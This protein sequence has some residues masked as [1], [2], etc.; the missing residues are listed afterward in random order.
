MATS[1]LRLIDTFPVGIN[2]LTSSEVVRMDF[3]GAVVPALADNAGDVTALVGVTFGG[4]GNIGGVMNVVTAG[5]VDVRCEPGLTLKSSQNLYVSA[6]IAGAVTNVQPGANATPIGIVKNATH[7]AASGL[8]A[9]TLLSSPGASSNIANWLLVRYFLVSYD[10]GN[11]SNVGFIDAAPGAVL[12]PTGK[13]IKTITRLLQ[14]LPFYG[15]NHVV[16]VLI[17]PRAGGVPYLTPLGGPETLDVRG[18]GGYLDGVIRGSDLTNSA[19][20]KLMC[21]GII[22]AGTNAAGYVVT[23]THIAISNATNTNPIHITLPPGHNLGNG[24]VIGL[25][26]VLGNTAANGDWFLINVVGNLADLSNSQGNGAYISGGIIGSGDKTWMQ[27]TKVGGAPA[28]LP[29]FTSSMGDRIHWTFGANAGTMSTNFCNGPGTLMV[30]TNVAASVSVGDVL[31]LELPGVQLANAFF[32]NFANTNL[33]VVG[34]NLNTNLTAQGSGAIRFAFCQTQPLLFASLQECGSLILDHRY[35]DE[36]LATRICGGNRWAGHFIRDVGFLLVFNSSFFDN[37]QNTIQGASSYSFGTGCSYFGIIVLT[38]SGVAGGTFGAQTVGRATSTT[39]RRL[40]QLGDDFL[41]ELLQINGSS[42]AIYGYNWGSDGGTSENNGAVVRPRGVGMSWTIDDVTGAYQAAPTA[43]WIDLALSKASNYVFGTASVNPACTVNGAQPPVRYADGSYG[44]FEDYLSFDVTDGAKNHCWGAGGCNT[45]QAFSVPVVGGAMTSKQIA[46]MGTTAAPAQANAGATSVGVIGVAVSNTGNLIV[47]VLNADTSSPINVTTNGTHGLN[48]TLTVKVAGVVGQTGLNGVWTV[49]V[50]GANTFQAI[51]S[52]SVAPYVS[53]GTI[54]LTPVSIL[55][56]A[57]GPVLFDAPPALGDGAWLS[58]ANPGNAANALPA[59]PNEIVTCGTVTA[60]SSVN[61]SIGIVS[62]PFTRSRA[63]TKALVDAASVVGI[64][65]S[66]NSAFQLTLTASGH[67]V[68]AP[69]NPQAGQTF[70]IE[71][72]QSAGGPWTVTLATGSAGTF[73]F[74]NAGS[75]A[76]GTLA[77]FNAELAAATNTGRV[78]VTFQYNATAQ[79]CDVISIAG[80]R[81]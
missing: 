79:R 30:S 73:A 26:G 25:S 31:L 64:D 40:W 19:A 27:V 46:R 61:S 77:A 56:S 22:A 15:N 52:V 10:N 43:N 63:T 2:G 29:K 49:N 75:A 70:T 9:C 68:A 5:E 17:E 38:S 48:N 6:S 34:L 23:A 60:I 42:G 72:V 32:G 62:G 74:A 55:V 36:A 54:Q 37:Q 3:T 78:A 66:L 53:G 11:D 18:Y 80:F 35:A 57:R 81:P 71:F 8:V 47:P 28:A 39:S 1:S 45:D 67:V 44:Y 4:T 13:A 59:P 24:D 65:L 14:I 50:T 33:S 76:N 12:N 51:G 7:Y 58:P 20:D 69:T 16:A 21:G 41:D